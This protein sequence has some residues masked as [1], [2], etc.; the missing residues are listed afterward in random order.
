VQILPRARASWPG[1]VARHPV[2]CPL[3]SSRVEH[4]PVT[5]RQQAGTLLGP[6]L[7][8]WPELKFFY[9]L[10]VTSI[11]IRMYEV[12]NIDKK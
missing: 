4:S 11:F 1:G 12:L 7:D 9:S 3:G 5:I 2:E 8:A 6:C 10:F